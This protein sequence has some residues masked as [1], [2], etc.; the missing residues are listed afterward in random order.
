MLPV[1]LRVDYLRTLVSILVLGYASIVDLKTRE[2]HDIVWIT[3]SSIG[4]ILIAYEILRGTLTLQTVAFSVGFMV[5]L[6]GILWY[7]KLFGEADLIAFIVLALIHPRTPLYG[8]KGFPPLLFSFTLIAN[9][10][11]SGLIPAIATGFSNIL[12]GLRGVDLFERQKNTPM[13]TR[14]ALLFTGR[15]KKVKKIRGPPFEYPLEVN[16][17][18]SMTPNIYDDEKAGQTLN[19]LR[20]KGWERI[21][22]SVTLPY[23]L[24]LMIG[25]LLSIWYGDILFSV[26]TYLSG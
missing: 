14:L 10:A 8:F 22:V 9:S 23:I 19:I 13:T 11:L 17:S 3:P 24:N 15:Y 4:V 25:Y 2:I 5:A 18:I 1:S 21:W 16:G 12:T 6:S 26:M 20:E 7:L